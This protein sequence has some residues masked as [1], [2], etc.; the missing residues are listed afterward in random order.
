MRS[1]YETGT[2]AR[3]F[4]DVRIA[5]LAVLPRL[6]VGVGVPDDGRRARSG[7]GLS[8]DGAP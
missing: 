5:S 3:E 8:H 7:L 1:S 2:R 6:R 4:D